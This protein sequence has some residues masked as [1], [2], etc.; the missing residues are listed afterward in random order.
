MIRVPMDLAKMREQGGGNNATYLTLL[1]TR[2]E[3]E[4][5]AIGRTLV[6]SR[7][8]YRKI[9]GLLAF[10][11]AVNVARH[12]PKHI[13]PISPLGNSKLRQSLASHLMALCHNDARRHHASLACR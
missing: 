7:S 11:D 13:F 10:Q 6:L 9:S 1:V 5:F 8:L 4:P 12:A 3:A 2:L